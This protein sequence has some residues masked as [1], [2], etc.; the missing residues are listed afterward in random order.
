MVSTINPGL[1]MTKA[2]NPEK[3]PVHELLGIREVGQRTAFVQILREH[4][5]DAQKCMEMIHGLAQKYLQEGAVD[6]ALK[7]L[8]AADNEI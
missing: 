7:V 8:L 5:G 6:E 3:I 1:R 4:P 2:I